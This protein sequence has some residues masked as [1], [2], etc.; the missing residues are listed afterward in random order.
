[1]HATA[2]IRMR[3]FC[4]LNIRQHKE[5]LGYLFFM[6]CRYSFFPFV[7][8]VYLQRSA[9]LGVILRPLHVN[10]FHQTSI[11]SCRLLS[12]VTYATD[13]K[14]L[15]S[16]SS[17][18]GETVRY[19]LLQEKIKIILNS[20]VICRFWISTVKD[21]GNWL[22]V[23][24]N[25]SRRGFLALP[26]NSKTIPGR[27]KKIVGLLDHRGLYKYLDKCMVFS[28]CELQLNYSKCNE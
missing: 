5:G 2:L 16:H 18:P 22:L 11:I 27:R 9:K 6:R 12:S 7:P 8:R 24:K 15:P 4:S 13:F 23:F 3:H 26:F 28:L 1:M 25:C 10:L 21:N 20:T 14:T 17:L 19:K